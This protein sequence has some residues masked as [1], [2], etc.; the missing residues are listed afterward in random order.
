MWV[1]QKNHI[2]QQFYT[3]ISQWYENHV[4]RG[5]EENFIDDVLHLCWDALHPDN[6]RLLITEHGNL[7]IAIESD[8]RVSAEKSINEWAKCTTDYLLTHSSFTNLFKEEPT[9]FLEGIGICQEEKLSSFVQGCSSTL[10]PD[11]REKMR[12]V[13]KIGLWSHASEFSSVLLMNCLIRSKTPQIDQKNP[14]ND[15]HRWRWLIC[16]TKCVEASLHYSQ[17]VLALRA[18]F[19]KELPDKSYTAQFRKVSHACLLEAV[20]LGSV[21]LFAMLGYNPNQSFTPDSRL[22]KAFFPAS[23]DQDFIHFLTISYIA[24]AYESANRRKW[25]P[26][27]TAEMSF[28]EIATII[29]MHDV[30]CT[31]GSLKT[32]M[33]DYRK[34]LDKLCTIVVV[35]CHAIWSSPA[36]FF[37]KRQSREDALSFEDFSRLQPINFRKQAQGQSYWY[38]DVIINLYLTHLTQQMPE[39][40]NGR[41]NSYFFPKLC[42]EA[43]ERPEFQQTVGQPDYN[44]VK[45]HGRSCVKSLGMQAVSSIFDLNLLFVPINEKNKHW[46]LAVVFMKEKIVKFYEPLGGDVNQYYFVNLVR[47]LNREW[48]EKM[49][50]THPGWRSEQPWRS[51]KRQDNGKCIQCIMMF[52]VSSPLQPSNF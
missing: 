50:T 20:I 16:F 38:N 7:F 41:F 15:I 5:P 32:F 8:D 47:Y 31:Y 21:E 12:A 52:S 14:S 30:K 27:F 2:P 37:P 6:S 44:N 39:T 29:F 9:D 26:L 25:T 11:K 48:D 45:N 19:I 13:M 23:P 28:L 18:P 17:H 40:K 35:L 4:N 34:N 42:N 51:P 33:Q 43:D 3:D 24:F 1:K 49:G 10:E 36:Q 22:T 46:I